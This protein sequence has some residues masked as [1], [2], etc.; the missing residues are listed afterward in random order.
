MKA[1]ITIVG[2]DAVGILAKASGVCA[3]RNAHIGDVTQTVMQEIFTMVM[4]VEIDRL[5]GSIAELDADLAEALK[6]QG[7]VSQVMHEDI[8]NAMHR[9]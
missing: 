6:G 3:A 2:H 7:L 5:S 4:L 9:I 1:V 8:F